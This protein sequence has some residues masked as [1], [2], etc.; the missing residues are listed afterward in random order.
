[1]SNSTG[2]WTKA[3][4][5]LLAAAWQCDALA[6]P[7]APTARD[8]DQTTVH[9][10]DLNIDQTAGAAVLYRRIRNAAKSVCGEPQLPGSRAVSPDWR[11]CVAQ[12]IDGA[13]VAVDRPAL[14]VYHRVHTTPS[15]RGSSKA[16][17]ASSQR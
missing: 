13:V 7:E 14:T 12:A 16:L 1:M 10:G 2:I 8:V 9:F 5:L 15:E 3:A 6:A 17:A 4:L 11:R